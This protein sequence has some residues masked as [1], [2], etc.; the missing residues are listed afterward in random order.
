MFDMPVLAGLPAE[1]R[2]A[3]AER[4]P[5]NGALEA[6]DLS[7]EAMAMRSL[8]PA[9]AVVWAGAAP[10]AAAVPQVLLVGDGAIVKSTMT[11]SGV[12]TS[13]YVEPDDELRSR[14]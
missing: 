7:V 9:L 6:L 10:G 1:V 11:A 5:W 3:L 13:W 8:T 4:G 12:T 2:S 14:T